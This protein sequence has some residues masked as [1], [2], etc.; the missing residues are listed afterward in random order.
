MFS[1][2][3]TGVNV[4]ASRGCCW[5]GPSLPQ[6]ADAHTALPRAAAGVGKGQQPRAAARALPAGRCHPSP[7]AL[8]LVGFFFCFKLPMAV[9][10]GQGE[11]GLH[12][13][14]NTLLLCGVLI[15]GT[16]WMVNPLSHFPAAEV[17]G[18]ART[19]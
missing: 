5:C 13:T 1:I 18:P 10:S 11:G 19:Q 6:H 14:I 7:A 8:G 2:L 9:V 16:Q 12:L 4:T 17:T 3:C 15:A